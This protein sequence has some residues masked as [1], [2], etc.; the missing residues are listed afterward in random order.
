MIR[1]RVQTSEWRRVKA[2]V[3]RVTAAPATWHQSVMTACLVGGPSAFASHTTAATLWGLEGFR[4]GEIHISTA[5]RPRA[6]ERVSFHQVVCP[7]PGDVQEIGPIAVSSPTRTLLELSARCPA[8]L[9]EIALD[10]ALRRRLTSIARIRW[11]LDK[12]GAKGRPGVRRLRQLATARHRTPLPESALERR[13]LRMLSTK[14]LPPPALQYVVKD[15]DGFVARLDFAY[16]DLKVAIEVDGYRHHSG[17]LRWERDRARS[18][19]LE[20]AGWRV[21]RATSDQLRARPDEVFG[22]LARLLPEQGTLE[23]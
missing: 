18:N 20:A 10:D 15:E 21:I 19:R 14:K 12:V 4:P 23:T 7:P 17:R 22:P 5:A 9:L 11:R 1:T 16:P 2:G 8:E 6:L 13:F 3:F